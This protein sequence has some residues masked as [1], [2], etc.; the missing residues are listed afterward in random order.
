M[1]LAD[2]KHKIKF[3][4]IC[5]SSDM[6]LVVFMLIPLVVIICNYQNFTSR[7][8]LEALGSCLVNKYAEGYPGARYDIFC[9]VIR[10]FSKNRAFL[11]V[12]Y[13]RK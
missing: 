5:H 6:A 3:T 13:I 7:A 10:Y 2:K 9:W 4:E 8:V 12:W 11:Q 1:L